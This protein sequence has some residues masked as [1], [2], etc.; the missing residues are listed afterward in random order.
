[1]GLKYH[2]RKF[3]PDAFVYFY[4]SLFVSNYY[5]YNQE[6]L[7]LKRMP[8]FQSGYSNLL[9][10]AIKFADAAS[11]LYEYETILE[12]EI[13]K[14]KSSNNKPFIID[15]GDNIGL[16]V[17]YFKRLF[18][19][20]EVLC[21]EPDK[22]IFDILNDNINTFNLKNVTAINKAVWNENVVKE[23]SSE[24][25][26]AGRLSLNSDKKTSMVECIKLSSFINRKV[27]FLKIDI[28]GAEVVV[29]E[30]IQNCL[31]H[32]NYIYVEYHSFVS[33]KQDLSDLLGILTDKGFRYY[34]KDAANSNITNQF[35]DRAIYLEMDLQLHIFAI[36]NNLN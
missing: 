21:F 22:V 1:M 25:A 35:I 10:P 14:F 27:D 4:K 11:F 33:K 18:T 5:N 30:E 12:K 20:S 7:R 23:F 26:D 36:N 3:I 8:R 15:C 32:V 13:Y 6:K 29:F 28:E 24:G 31:Q 17:L 2:I 19:E 16:S 34:I 9:I